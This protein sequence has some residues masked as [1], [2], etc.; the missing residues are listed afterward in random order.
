MC[1]AATAAL[2]LWFELADLIIHDSQNVSL[3]AVSLHTVPSGKGRRKVQ[4]KSS[5]AEMSS[6]K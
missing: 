6:H 4:L 2:A 3:F 5:E 1:A